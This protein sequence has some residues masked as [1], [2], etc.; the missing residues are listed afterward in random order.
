[1]DIDL[2]YTRNSDQDYRII[3]DFD[4]KIEQTNKWDYSNGSPRKH[5]YGTGKVA[6]GRHKIKIRSVNGDVR[7]KK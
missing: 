3:S 7:I 4:F 2:G 6:G 5:I 1:M